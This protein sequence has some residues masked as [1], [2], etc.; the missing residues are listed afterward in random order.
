MKVKRPKMKDGRTVVRYVLSGKDG[1]DSYQAARF[2]G[3]PG[4]F[5]VPFRSSEKRSGL[6]IDCDVTGLEPLPAICAATET[7][8]QFFGLLI[9]FER[10]FCAVTDQHLPIRS[11]QLDPNIV[12][13]DFR[14]QTLRFI[15]M[16]TRVTQSNLRSMY[17]LL[18]SL[19]G[20]VRWGAND[21][22]PELHRRYCE[23]FAVPETFSVAAF[24][25]FAR[26]L[27]GT[28]S[29]EYKGSINMSEPTA[30][31][32]NDF[33]VLSRA[34]RDAAPEPEDADWDATDYLDGYEPFYGERD[35]RIRIVRCVN[36]EEVLIHALP[37]TVGKGPEADCVLAG[38]SAISRVHARLCRSGLAFTIED[39][40][41]TNGTWC[42]GRK[43][44]GGERVPLYPGDHFMLA[45]EKFLFL[46]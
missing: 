11:L 8:T 46:A 36:D 33:A 43:L 18:R 1:Y 40:G 39:L 25:A 30:P 23:F 20:G 29:L 34:W 26:E 17:G 35:G 16:P 12:F 15:L 38:N 45:D 5:I 14:T 44:G 22:D 21:L 41:S 4:E 28:K 31:A 2:I 42:H 3:T 7:R 13:Y 27:T 24:R 37:A 19:E 32:E 10:F 9:A 6:V